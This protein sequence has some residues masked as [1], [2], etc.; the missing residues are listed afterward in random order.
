MTER[1]AK[2]KEGQK[3]IPEGNLP[4]SLVDAEVHF[5]VDFDR[6]GAA[7]EGCRLEFVLLH[8]LDGL[9]I[10]P[11]AQVANHLNPLWISLRVHDQ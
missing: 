11:H 2:D 1:K 9:L 4:R 3:Q 10:Q 8:C 7:L 5:D 6:D